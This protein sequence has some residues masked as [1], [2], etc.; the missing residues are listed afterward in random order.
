MGTILPNV[1]FSGVVSLHDPA[2]A[3]ASFDGIQRVLHVD[4]ADRGNRSLTARMN[5]FGRQWRSSPT[6]RN[7]KM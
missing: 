3:C 1:G 2:K 4:A 7:R 6:I 5:D